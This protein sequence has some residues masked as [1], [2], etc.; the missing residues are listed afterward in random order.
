MGLDKGL[1]FSLLFFAFFLNKDLNTALPK[2]GW[3]KETTCWSPNT[4]G[5]Q[6]SLSICPSLE[7]F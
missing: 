3:P 5:P 1:F 4:K 7:K 6:T 2:T